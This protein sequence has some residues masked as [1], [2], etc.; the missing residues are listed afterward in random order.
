LVEF[1]RQASA[2]LKVLDDIAT[3]VATQ[4]ELYLQEEIER[5]V[6]IQGE[7]Q[8]ATISTEVRQRYTALVG[9]GSYPFLLDYCAVDRVELIDYYYRPRVET[10]INHV[11][12]NLRGAIDYSFLLQGPYKTIAQSFVDGTY[13]PPVIF[14]SG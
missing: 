14:P 1:N 12:D 2:S 13:T 7:N 6:S 5:G 4:E 10:W 8:R 9:M 3:L 11:R